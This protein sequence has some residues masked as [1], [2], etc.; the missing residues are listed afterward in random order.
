MWNFWHSILFLINIYSFQ[1][2]V[3]VCK[4]AS[5]SRS[6]LLLIQLLFSVFTCFLMIDYEFIINHLYLFSAS[7]MFPVSFVCLLCL[8]VGFLSKFLWWARKRSILQISVFVSCLQCVALSCFWCW[9]CFCQLSASLDSKYCYVISRSSSY[10]SSHFLAPFVVFVFNDKLPLLFQECFQHFYRLQ[11]QM[12]SSLSTTSSSLSVS[13]R[14]LQGSVL[15]K[16]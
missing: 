16:N 10:M 14:Q 12:P 6:H 5:L 8:F 1:S 11:Y 15:S 2:L 3:L 4:S 13:S 9:S 7:P